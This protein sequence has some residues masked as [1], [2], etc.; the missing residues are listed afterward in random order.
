[1][2]I[3][4]FVKKTKVTYVKVTGNLHGYVVPTPNESVSYSGYIEVPYYYDDF[5]R[6]NEKQRIAICQAELSKSG[7]CVKIKTCDF[8]A[9]F[10]E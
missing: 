10:K 4:D 5:S 3:E 7:W 6:F 9:F 1:M 8:D 2:N